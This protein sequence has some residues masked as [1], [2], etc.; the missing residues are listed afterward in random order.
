MW[1]NYRLRC[2]NTYDWFVV[3]DKT[4]SKGITPIYFLGIYEELIYFLNNIKEQIHHNEL[5]IEDLHWRKDCCYEKPKKYIIYDFPEWQD[6]QYVYYNETDRAICRRNDDKVYEKYY[7][8]KGDLEY[9]L[10]SHLNIMEFSYCKGSSLYWVRY[11]LDTDKEGVIRTRE[12]KWN[13]H[14]V[15]NDDLEEVKKI[16]NRMNN[17]KY[18]SFYNDDIELACEKFGVGL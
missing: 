16:L 13:E 10:Y 14:K 2:R 9:K 12:E 17:K 18:K 8:N 3:F 7:Y 6:K 5:E 11:H 1:E 4:N 15:N